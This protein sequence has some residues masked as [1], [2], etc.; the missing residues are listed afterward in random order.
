MTERIA[1]DEAGDLLAIRA[2]LAHY[3]KAI[4]VKNL[5]LMDDVFTA[6]AMIDYSGIGGS[7]GVVGRR[8]SRGWAAWC[9]TSSCSC[10]TSATCTRRSHPTRAPPRSRAT[11]H[12]VFVA[13]AGAPPLIVFGTY[14]D[15]FVRTP[16]GWRIS[17]RIDHPGGAGPRRERPE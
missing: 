2:V 11:W 1:A 5:E 10:S 14:L 4:R 12:G 8:R 9:S 6:D 13:E 7:R 17:E 15:Q 3:M 16:D